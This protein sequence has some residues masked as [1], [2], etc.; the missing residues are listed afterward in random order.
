MIEFLAN[1]D[2]INAINF[3]I[4]TGQEVYPGR[5]DNGVCKSIQHF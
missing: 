2:A 5:E 3:N 1:E 4:L